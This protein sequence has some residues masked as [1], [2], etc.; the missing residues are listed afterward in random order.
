MPERLVKSGLDAAARNLVLTSALEVVHEGAGGLDLRGN[1]AARV[2]SRHAEA[3]LA[4]SGA[5]C[6]FVRLSVEVTRGGISARAV[7]IR[8]RARAAPREFSRYAHTLSRH[9]EGGAR[10]AVSAA[11]PTS[12]RARRALSASALSGQAAGGA[13]A[14]QDTYPLTCRCVAGRRS[15]IAFAHTRR[16]A[17]VADGMPGRARSRASDG[18]HGIVHAARA[19]GIN[20]VAAARSRFVG[21]WKAEDFTGR[22]DSLAL[23]GD[24]RA[25]RAQRS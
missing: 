15:R 9:P 6:G 19:R 5:S 11:A 17:S 25:R 7:G 20:E 22:G 14:A 16:R 21:G 3:R 2:A 23:T 12:G 1:R 13:R 24:V 18:K 8:G 4:S 10:C